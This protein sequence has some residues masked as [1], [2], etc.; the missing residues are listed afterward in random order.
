MHAF[1]AF[2]GSPAVA[3][4]VQRRAVEEGLLVFGAGAKPSRIRLLPPLNVTD[5]ELDAGFAMLE[6]ALR[7]AGEERGLTC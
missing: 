7:R 4:L 2:D 6:K 3:D 1:V 5:E